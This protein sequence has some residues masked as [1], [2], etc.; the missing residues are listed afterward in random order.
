MNVET[1]ASID[2]SQG[3]SF[4]LE[5]HG[6]GIGGFLWDAEVDG[7]GSIEKLSSDLPAGGAIGGGSVARF[8]L[9]WVGKSGGAVRFVRK[10]PWSGETSTERT[11]EVKVVD[12]GA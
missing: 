6:E 11:I 3:L 12:R 9:T 4:E 7:E 8:R 2:L 10:R 1:A 5:A